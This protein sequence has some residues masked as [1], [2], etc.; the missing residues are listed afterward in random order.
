M[1]VLNLFILFLR[2]KKSTIINT[3]ISNLLVEHY[4]NLL[5]PSITE[6]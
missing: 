4:L 1:L 3:T 5:N 2:R 6:K